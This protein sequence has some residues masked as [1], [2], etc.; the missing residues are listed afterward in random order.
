MYAVSM[1]IASTANLSP[2]E[3]LLVMVMGSIG[4]VAPVQGGIGTFHAL[5]A[6]ILIQLGIAEQDG[7]IFAAIIHG[8]QLILI[9]I[10]GLI[11]WVY[12]LQ[13]PAWKK[14]ESA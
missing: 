5:V 13:K 1:G 3:V 11:S 12:M 7:K 10:A 8:T 4:M 14:P 2:G 6:F 9:L